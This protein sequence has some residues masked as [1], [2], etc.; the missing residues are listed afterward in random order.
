MIPVQERP[1]SR[2]YWWLLVTLHLYCW[3][4]AYGVLTI[5]G[6]PVTYANAVLP[7]LLLS[8]LAARPV[9]KEWAQCLLLLVA[10]LVDLMFR[11]F[12][13]TWDAVGYSVNIGKIALFVLVAS[14]VR[15]LPVVRV[16]GLAIS[17]GIA[18]ITSEVFALFNPE[19]RMALFNADSV[20]EGFGLELF[21]PTGLIG[22]PNYF[23]LP[24]ALMAVAAYDSRRYWLMIL[25]MAFVIAS[26]SRSAAIA[27]LIPIFILQLG[28]SYNRPARMIAILLFYVMG[29]ALVV[30]ANQ[31]LREGTTSES[32]AE[33]LGLL[34]QAFQNIAS[35]SFLESTYGQPISKALDGSFLVVHNTFLQTLSTSLMLGI[36]YIYRSF[37]GFAAAPTRMLFLSIFIEMYFLDLSAQSSFVL[38]FLLVSS[39]RSSVAIP[40]MAPQVPDGKCALFHSSPTSVVV[41]ASTHP[42]T[43]R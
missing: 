15:E 24:V 5:P 9:R 22:D 40:A 4:S 7:L 8:G 37:R 20:A 27:S 43:A 32:T 13:M 18:T 6:T 1:S 14:R 12:T 39:A 33:R 11:E 26:G 34:L 16:N 23:A 17:F 29:A 36:F 31:M 35:F 41:A 3:A 42:L 10:M 21:R 19:Y 25:A 28:R 30:L 38:F 2:G